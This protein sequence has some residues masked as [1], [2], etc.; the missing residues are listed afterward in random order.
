MF[1]KWPVLGP[2]KK[3]INDDG[4]GYYYYYSP[5]GACETL[6]RVLA[7]WDGVCVTLWL[8]FRLF[9][10]HDWLSSVFTRFPS[11]D[12]SSFLATLRREPV[13]T[14]I[15]SL[16]RTVTPSQPALPDKALFK[17]LPVQFLVSPGRLH[18]PQSS[19]LL[20]FAGSVTLTGTE[21]C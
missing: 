5:P 2:T 8:D 9:E 1:R 3:N 11:L 7:V 10:K 20:E 14:S 6:D 21:G 15:C 16:G 13:N 18:F 12:L 19:G 4:Y 17:V